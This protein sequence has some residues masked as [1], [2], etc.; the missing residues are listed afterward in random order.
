M[1][2]GIPNRRRVLH[3]GGEPFLFVSDLGYEVSVW[4]RF[5]KAFQAAVRLSVTVSPS[6]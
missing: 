3:L 4:N 6:A 1:R 2:Q 5:T